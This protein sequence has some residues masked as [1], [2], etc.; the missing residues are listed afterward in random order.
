M[1]TFEVF[2]IDSPNWSQFAKK[3]SGDKTAFCPLKREGIA[4]RLGC[5][6]EEHEK[7]T[8]SLSDAEATVEWGSFHSK[9]LRFISKQAGSYT[10]V[11]RMACYPCLMAV[12]LDEAA[13]LLPGEVNNL[14]RWFIELMTELILRD[15][16]QDWLMTA[17]RTE[18]DWTDIQLHECFSRKDNF[19]D[20]VDLYAMVSGR[21]PDGVSFCK[22]SQSPH[23]KLS[24]KSELMLAFSL[25][26]EEKKLLEWA[27]EHTP[28][29]G[30]NL[31][32]MAADLFRL[33]MFLFDHQAYSLQVSFPLLV[34]MAVN[35]QVV[36]EEASRAEGSGAYSLL[37]GWD[38]VA[39]GGMETILCNI[40]EMILKYE[41]AP[42]FFR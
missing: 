34:M 11:C 6:F 8:L 15:S 27:T 30:E 5:M 13:P 1:K 10:V 3:Y 29:K 2:K 19:W 26:E 32:W 33:K 17:V 41:K 36:V 39:Q 23:R 9:C 25:Q 40:Q 14:R 35:R 7:E 16:C 18:V 37:F 4:C 28:F 42:S 38:M 24:P 31:D 20:L 21:Q 12:E 22:A